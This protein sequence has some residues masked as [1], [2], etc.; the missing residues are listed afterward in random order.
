MEFLKILKKFVLIY[1]SLI[2]IFSLTLFIVSSIP[3]DPIRNNIKQSV[4]LFMKEGDYPRIAGNHKINQ[5]DNY[6]ESVMLNII[7]NI[8]ENHPVESVLRAEFYQIGPDGSMENLRVTSLKALVEDNVEPNIDY[9][10]YWNGYIII[11][12]PLLAFLSYASIRKLMQILFYLLFSIIVILL[13]KKVSVISAIAFSLSMILINFMVIPLTIHA[14]FIFFIVFI[15]MIILLLF[16][17]LSNNNAVFLFFIFGALTS[18]MDL[19]TAPLVTFGLPA[20]TLLLLRRQREKTSSIKDY[21]LFLVYI[22]ISWIL[23]YALLWGTK[24]ILASIALH[25]NIIMDGINAVIFRISHEVPFGQKFE[26]NAI[27]AIIRNVQTL[28]TYTITDYPIIYFA[29]PCLIIVV[30]VL[31]IWHRKKADLLFPSILVIIGLS[32][33]LWF[34]FAANHS[35]IHHWFTCRIQSVTIFSFLV[36]FYYFIDWQ[37]M[38][39]DMKKPGALIR[40]SKDKRKRRK[41]QVSIEKL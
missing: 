10:R 20:I 23:G 21:I 12:R 11:V 26:I 13:S 28:Y 4:P 36:A 41:L 38:K 6:A 16:P 37:K 35:Y 17:N 18:F 33:Y 31:S 7:Y 40:A 14:S 24:W 3:S 29:L 8:D 1:F 34:A 19:L 15:F 5:L 32:P 22:S 30:L 25:E 39:A 27:D 2:L 9:P